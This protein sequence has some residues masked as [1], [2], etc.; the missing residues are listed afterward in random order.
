MKLDL[1]GRVLRVPVSIARNG[2]C[3]M[4]R[5][6]STRRPPSPRVR[7]EGRD[8]G[9]FPHAQTRGNA[10][11]PA[12]LRASTSP[13]KRAEVKQGYTNRL[14]STAAPTKDANRGCGSNGRDLSS[15]WNCTPMNQG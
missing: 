14:G 6:P 2:C 1:H 11:S 3:E 9:A 15:G 5:G 7:G 4:V 12:A 10:P 13:R 8:E